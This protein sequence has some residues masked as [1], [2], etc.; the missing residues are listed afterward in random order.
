MEIN[1]IKKEGDKLELE[2]NDLT[3]VNLLHETLWTK[4]ID[5]SAYNKDHPFLTKPLLLVKAK[6]A[7]KVLI[8]ASETIEANTEELKKKFQKAVK[9]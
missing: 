9:G 5:Y 6:D 3:F 8:D 2:I 7:K 4:K 1:L